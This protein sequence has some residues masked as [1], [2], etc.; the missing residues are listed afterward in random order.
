L[1][2]LLVE[3]FSRATRSHGSAVKL[4]I[5]KMLQPRLSYLLYSLI[6]HHQKEYVSISLAGSQGKCYRGTLIEGA[7][8]NAIGERSS[9]AHLSKRMRPV[10]VVV[11]K[12][13][14]GVM[15][16][17]WRIGHAT[18]MCDSAVLRSRKYP[19]HAPTGTHDCYLHT[20]R[21]CLYLLVSNI[22]GTPATINLVVACPILGTLLV[23]SGFDTTPLPYIDIA[24]SIF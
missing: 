2:C 14:I 7:R 8:E 18:S 23:I 3:Y 6:Y 19:Q 4:L 12:K 10:L 5:M 16:A 24:F 1:V 13:S 21:V 22:L 15:A 17:Q 20:G 11:C 9:V